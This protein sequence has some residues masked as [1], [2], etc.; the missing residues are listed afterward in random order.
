VFGWVVLWLA[1]GWTWSEWVAFSQGALVG[2]EAIPWRIGPASS[3]GARLRDILD[4]A[5]PTGWQRRFDCYL[6]YL[7]AV[8]RDD[9][10]T[11]GERLRE[12]LDMAPAEP[13]LLLEV[14]YYQAIFRDRPDSSMAWIGHATRA[15]PVSPLLMHR[16]MAA[17]RL[18]SGDAQG[19]V[20]HARCALGLARGPLAGLES[21]LA[22]EIESAATVLVHLQSGQNKRVTAGPW[23]HVA[24][25]VQGG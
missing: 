25:P 11:A 13:T 19:A 21:R 2:A 22:G 6:S 7:D 10:A 1:T 14:A 12:L 17:A 8:Q 5:G 3:G 9:G 15:G 18:A 23:D 20:P 24:L 4:G 16:A